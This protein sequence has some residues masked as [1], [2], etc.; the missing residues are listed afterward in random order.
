LTEDAA[1]QIFE[2][3]SIG[4]NKRL[5]VA[6]SEGWIRMAAKIGRGNMEPVMR[7][8]TKLVRLRNEIIDLA[9]LPDNELEAAVTS[10]FDQAWASVKREGR[11]WG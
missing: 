10:F 3:A 5:A 2:R 9:G 7:L 11:S 8:A 4:G 6:L 1:V